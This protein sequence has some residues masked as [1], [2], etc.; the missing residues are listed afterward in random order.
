MT[1]SK[2]WVFAE[3]DRRQVSSTVLEVLTKAR[4]LA[5]LSRRSTPGPTPTP[6]PAPLGGPRRH[7]RPRHRRARRRPARVCPWPPR[8]PPPSGGRSRRH[9]VRHRLHARDVVGR[10]SV[11]LDK[12]VLTNGVDLALEG[13]SLAVTEPVFGGDT[14]VVDHLHRRRPSPGRASGRSRSRPRRAV[15]PPPRSARWPCPTRARRPGPR[16]PSATSRSSRVPSSRTPPSWCRAA[17]A[18]ARPRSTR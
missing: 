12:P 2:I 18:S 1:L 6:W 15:A 11:A 17:G 10:L 9:P 4:E 8:W 16:S 14:N 13:D 7:Q 3:A 5:D